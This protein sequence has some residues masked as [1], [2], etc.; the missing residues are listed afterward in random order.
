[1]AREGREGK[2]KDECSKKKKVLFSPISK[3]TVIS[4]SRRKPRGSPGCFSRNDI[5]AHLNSKCVKTE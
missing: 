4:P 2:R 1:M 5:F 3:N